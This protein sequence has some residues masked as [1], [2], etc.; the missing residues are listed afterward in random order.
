[1]KFK[2]RDLI[3]IV[4]SYLYEQDE[5]EEEKENELVKMEDFVIEK[6]EA[7]FMLNFDKKSID[8]TIEKTDTNLKDLTGNDAAGYLNVALVYAYDQKNIKN[9]VEICHLM[10]IFKPE[11]AKEKIVQSLIKKTK[12]NDRSRLINNIFNQKIYNVSKAEAQ[13]II[14]ANLN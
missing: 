4:E 12:P 8:V 7:K 14:N 9:L 13:K 5:E 10:G 6:N 11:H 1:M 3:N 2:K